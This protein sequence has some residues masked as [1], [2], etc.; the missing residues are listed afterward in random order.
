MRESDRYTIDSG[1]PGRE[2]MMRAARGVFDSVSWK[3]PVAIVCGSGNNA[4]D[5]YA[6]ALLLH[7]AKI[8]TSVIT[9][10]EKFSE[11]GRYYFDECR[12]AGIPVYSWSELEAA[13]NLK[14]YATV[15]DCLLGTGFKGDLR[16]ELA[17]VIKAINSSGSY[18][19]SVDMNSGLNG[20]NGMAELCVRSKLTVSIGGFKPGHFLS[21]AKDVM[22][23][24]VNIDI[25]IKP[26]MKP[27]SLIEEEDVKAFFGRRA[28]FSNKGTYGYTALIGG[29]TRY[30]GAIR[31]AGLAEAAA[32][33][34]AGVVKIAVPS[35]LTGEVMPH[36]LV[37][38]LFPL[39]ENA[40]DGRNAEIMFVRSE[41]EELI[42]N[43]RT[44]AI[45]MGAGTGEGVKEMLE[46]L[47]AEFSGTLIADADALTVLSGSD[48]KKIRERR[49][50]LVLTPHIK[51]FSR[52]TG[53]DKE[54]I[55]S[56][57]IGAAKEYAADTG[58]VV[59]LKGPSTIVTDG[60]DVFITDRGCPGMATAGSGDVLSGILAAVLARFSP[61]EGEDC[62][63]GNSPDGGRGRSLC[64]MAAVGAYINGAAGELAEKKFGSVSMTAADTVGC[65]PDVLMGI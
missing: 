11:D 62:N 42:S 17:E 25:G 18:I 19:V 30:S 55:L 48:R 51:E 7:E 54:T 43:V 4:G 35:S 38:T 12:L 27:Y 44:V 33:S 57:P 52:L 49:C 8:E 37:S 39:S 16:P 53:K 9:C 15:V 46:F 32:R 3:A 21:M 50:S 23:D 24:K 61:G 47:L 1:T 10:S 41:A 36:I 20:D 64:F 34:G 13:G 26:V 29:C 5:G 14:D 22:E 59:L 2:L 63:D 60:K 28:N 65:I 58:S 45:G 31:L 6:L 40:A 56:D